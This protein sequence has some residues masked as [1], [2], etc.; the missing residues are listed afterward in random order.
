MRNRKAD[1]EQL[2]PVPAAWRAMPERTSSG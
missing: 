2:A 1:A